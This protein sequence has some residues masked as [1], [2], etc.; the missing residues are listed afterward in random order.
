MFVITARHSGAFCKSSSVQSCCLT[1]PKHYLSLITFCAK[2][3][4][5]KSR[6]RE[7]R[8][9]IDRQKYIKRDRQTDRP[10]TDK[11]GKKEPKTDKDGETE[12]ET[13]TEQRQ[14]KT[15]RER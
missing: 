14:R 6:R 2:S 13:E 15:K 9:E 7:E 1:T 12:L 3:L 5:L 10:Q 8:R 11:D 4:I